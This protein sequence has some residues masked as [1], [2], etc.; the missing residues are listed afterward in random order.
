M[1][2]I[3]DCMLFQNRVFTNKVEYFNIIYENLLKFLLFDQKFH[4]KKFL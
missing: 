1:I 3:H 2:Y 4:T